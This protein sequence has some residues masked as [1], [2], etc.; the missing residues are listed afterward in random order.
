M[1]RRAARSLL[2]LCIGIVIGNVLFIPIF[3]R[4]IHSGAV[5]HG[6]QELVRLVDGEVASLGILTNSTES[7]ERQPPPVRNSS[8]DG[9]VRRS[10]EPRQP[11]QSSITAV[12]SET[13]T[14]KPASLLSMHL[15]TVMFR[16]TS[17]EAKLYL[18][19][20]EH[21]T[22]LQRNLNHSLIT[23]VHI[24][25]ASR[26]EM[27]EYLHGL[28]LPNRHKVVVAESKQ[29]DTMRGVFQYISDNLADKD[30]LYANGDIY[31][32]NG[33]EKVDA[34]VLS[35][36]NIFYALSRLGKQ[37]EACKME[38]YCG[39]DVQY[40]GAHDAFLFHLNEPLPEEALKELEFKIWDY[41]AENILIGVFNKLLHYCTLNPCKVLE[42]YH[43]H[44]SAARRNDRV[45]V[46]TNSKFNGLSPFTTK[47]TC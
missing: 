35:E 1:A 42:C 30:V 12:T 29:W 36:R 41:G 21:A 40:I 11:S 33:F 5:Q 17:N 39:G 25:T 14:V 4:K 46:N 27:E 43:L 19:Q 22:V 15:V 38:D 31:L 26:K 18:R 34:N 9:D 7:A 16:S 23:S 47:L 2:M 10:D 28:D 13:T 8:V 45:R 6:K 44:C 20:K 37:E 3:M 24:I 32:G